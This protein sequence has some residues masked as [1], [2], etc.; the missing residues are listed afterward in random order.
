MGISMLEFAFNSLLGYEISEAV[1][2]PVGLPTPLSEE[3][4]FN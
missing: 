3:S 4:G 1:L 2:F